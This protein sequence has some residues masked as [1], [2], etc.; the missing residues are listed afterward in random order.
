ML[1]RTSRIWFWIRDEVYVAF[2]LDF[3]RWSLNT[4]SPAATRNCRRAQK[5]PCWASG[6][7]SISMV[8]SRW[9]RREMFCRPHNTIVSTIERNF[10]RFMATCCAKASLRRLLILGC[11]FF[12]TLRNSSICTTE[13]LWNSLLWCLPSISRAFWKFVSGFVTSTPG[14][15]LKLTVG[16]KNSA[17]GRQY[18][19][20]SLWLYCS[21]WYFDSQLCWKLRPFDVLGNLYKGPGMKCSSMRR[22]LSLSLTGLQRESTKAPTSEW[23]ILG[24]LAG[25]SSEAD[26]TTVEVEGCWGETGDSGQE[27][28]D[29]GREVGD[30]EREVEDSGQKVSVSGVEVGLEVEDSK[31]DLSSLSLYYIIIIIII[32]YIFYCDLKYSYKYTW[33]V[34]T[35][36]PHYGRTTSGSRS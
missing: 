11:L 25:S 30:S 19:P 35:S 17:H 14:S 21:H 32:I 28:G 8:L 5:L 1:P 23:Q 6:V 12:I 22:Y 31:V 33:N 24:R 26:S 3:A 13:D 9:P 7:R 10:W 18:P 15:D 2:L 36:Q 27:V 16:L 4:V 29:S 34:L 20:P